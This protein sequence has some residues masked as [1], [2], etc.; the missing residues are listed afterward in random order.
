MT[1]RKPLELSRGT[2]RPHGPRWD[3]WRGLLVA[4]WWRR[5]I[6]CYYCGHPFAGPQLI[7]AAHLISPIVRPDLAWSRDNL[8][9]A[10]GAGKNG[11]K[12]CPECRI[13]CNWVAHNAPDARHD[14]DGRDLPFTPELIAREIATAGN[15]R[16]RNGTPG[17]SREIPAPGPVIRPE[18]GR[19]W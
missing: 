17:I 11:V 2:A 10:H 6:P 7:E 12:R 4:A 13:N 1:R 5:Q 3:E 14:E 9:P 15:K 18:A 19:P 8:V 16:W